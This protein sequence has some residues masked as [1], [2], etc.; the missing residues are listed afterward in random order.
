[1]EKPSAENDIQKEKRGNAEPF[2]GGGKNRKRCSFCLYS[3]G[4]RL[5]E[6]MKIL[7]VDDAFETITGY[8]KDDIRKKAVLSG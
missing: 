6:D 2:G 7:S 3:S 8:S 4:Y 1:M 5:D